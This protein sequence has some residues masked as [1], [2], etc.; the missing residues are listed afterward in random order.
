MSIWD[1]EPKKREVIYRS[2]VCHVCRADLRLQEMR[3]H[4]YTCNQCEREQRQKEA[5]DDFERRWR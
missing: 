2:G 5:D 3:D 4:N 1:R